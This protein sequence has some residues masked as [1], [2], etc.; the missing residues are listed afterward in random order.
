M[1]ELLK[2]VIANF[3]FRGYI[4]GETYFVERPSGNK[5]LNSGKGLTEGD[6]SDGIDDDLDGIPDLEKDPDYWKD[7]KQK[8]IASPS[9]EARNKAK[10]KRKAKK[11]RR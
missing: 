10:A 7:N 9:P 1:T 5:T 4:P 6:N 8:F 11:R 3:A 2:P